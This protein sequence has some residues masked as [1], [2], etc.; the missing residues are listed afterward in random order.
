MNMKDQRYQEI[1][2]AGWR[3]ALNRDEAAALEKFLAAH[4]ETREAWGEESALNRFLERLP[5]PPVSSNFTS[6]LL[7]AVQAA[8]VRST[9]RDWFAPALWLPEGRAWRVAMCSMVVGV[10]LFS[11]REYQVLHRVRVARELAGV[12]RVA[13]LPPMEW[14]KDFD[15]INGISQ[16]KVADDDLLAALE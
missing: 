3:R 12:S 8:P 9:W 1:K 7:Q 10:G 11:F 2:E 4:P 16:V 15:T 14:L 13:A 5:A 6:R